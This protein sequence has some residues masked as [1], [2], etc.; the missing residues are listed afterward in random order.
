MTKIKLVMIFIL[1]EILLKTG[2]GKNLLGGNTKNH[3]KNHNKS[4]G[5]IIIF[6]GF[7]IKN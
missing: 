1:W 3:N 4:R 5:K 2:T 6:V 7:L